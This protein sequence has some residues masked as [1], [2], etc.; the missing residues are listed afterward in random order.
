MKTKK[1]FINSIKEI[2]KSILENPKYNYYQKV[3]AIT[4]LRIMEKDIIKGFKD[5]NTALKLNYS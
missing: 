3:F 5:L 4:S 1:D 2:E